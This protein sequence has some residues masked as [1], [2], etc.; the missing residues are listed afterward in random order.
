[1]SSMR[2]ACFKLIGINFISSEETYFS[3]YEFA[4]V[5]LSLYEV[6]FL[7]YFSKGTWVDH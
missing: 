5:Y 4:R 1:M 6:D 7:T 3:V 2:T